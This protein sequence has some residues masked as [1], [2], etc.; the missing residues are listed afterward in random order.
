MSMLRTFPSMTVRDVVCEMNLT[1]LWAIG[2][3][4]RLLEGVAENEAAKY[5][6]TQGGTK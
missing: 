2:E 3:Y 6:P 4:L 5:N 1:N